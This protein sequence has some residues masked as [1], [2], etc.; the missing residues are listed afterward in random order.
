MSDH[1]EPE[2]VRFARVART[3]RRL[4]SAE[5]YGPDHA[6][7]KAIVL[8]G[9]AF[10]ETH[11]SQAPELLSLA[12]LLKLALFLRR[13]KEEASRSGRDCGE[14]HKHL[15]D[16]RRRIDQ[17][18]DRILV[19]AEPEQMTLVF[20]APSAEEILSRYRRKP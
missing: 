13:R 11:R 6:E 20:G 4:E 1:R 15:I 12:K 16:V 19:S 10:I 17:R 3:W 18:V 2:I 8:D 9:V 14:I 5:Q 7:A